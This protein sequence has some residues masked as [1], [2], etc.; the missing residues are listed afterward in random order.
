MTVALA[1]ATILSLWTASQ[2]ADLTVITRARQSYSRT[3]Q[4]FSPGS[5]LFK[6]DLN[7]K[8][9]YVAEMYKRSMGRRYISSAEFSEQL[10]KEEETY[11][12]TKS[13]SPNDIPQEST[14]E[15]DFGK[16]TEDAIQD[17]VA[18]VE[19]RSTVPYWSRALQK[20]TPSSPVNSTDDDDAPTTNLPC[21]QQ[22]MVVVF[23][24][25]QCEL[26]E[27]AARQ[28][29]VFD[30]YYGSTALPTPDSIFQPR[31]L[32]MSTPIQPA[33]DHFRSFLDLQP[34]S[35]LLSKFTTVSN[36]E[37]LKEDVVKGMLID[38]L[39]EQLDPMPAVE[40]QADYGTLD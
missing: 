9:L 11:F 12:W 19:G 17:D 25:C 20:P 27:Q 16:L 36:Q 3:R 31:P 28:L 24:P 14:A 30:I 40:S 37:M 38:I 6:P 32:T 34:D 10:R 39:E 21:S 4:W 1:A 35:S 22:L 33:C 26:K 15:E 2:V 18:E 8:E 13:P 29:S 5:T 7:E 23:L